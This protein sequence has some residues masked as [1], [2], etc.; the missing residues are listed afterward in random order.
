[1]SET[2]FLLALN[3]T[4]K[5]YRW[6]FGP[7][8][9]TII[10]TARSGKGKFNPVTAV[11]RFFNRKTSTTNAAGTKLGLSLTLV[12]NIVSASAG[13]SNRG[14]AQVLRGKIRQV[15]GI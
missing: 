15:L 7:D 13:V 12:N 9:K 14:N 10:G 4:T 11:N 1:M 8:G 5:A 6:E 2:Q 3:K